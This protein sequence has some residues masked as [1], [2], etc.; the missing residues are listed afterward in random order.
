MMVAKYIYSILVE[1]R[2]TALDRDGQKPK[3][4]KNLNGNIHT[5]ENLC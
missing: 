3:Q 1:P 2:S 5:F 4:K